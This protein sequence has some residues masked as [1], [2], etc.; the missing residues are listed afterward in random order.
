MISGQNC[1][2]E[3]VMILSCEVCVGFSLVAMQNLYLEY[4]WGNLR[5]QETHAYACYILVAVPL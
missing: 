5:G 1:T 2:S 4:L 3:L